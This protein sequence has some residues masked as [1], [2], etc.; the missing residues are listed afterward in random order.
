MVGS[1]MI[2]EI[3]PD[4]GIKGESIDICRTLSIAFTFSEALHLS[5]V[6]SN[7]E[8]TS[9]FHWDPSSTPNLR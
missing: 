5:L 7:H 4:N 9:M 6:P 1:R 3:V 8:R 2:S